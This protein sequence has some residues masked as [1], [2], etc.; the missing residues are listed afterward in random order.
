M[1]PLPKLLDLGTGGE[2]S[3]AAAILTHTHCDCSVRPKHRV[4]SEFAHFVYENDKVM[5]ENFTERFIDHRHIGFAP[6]TVSK[7][8]FH[9]RE[10]G[11]H[12]AVQSP[13]ALPPDLVA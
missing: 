8:A 9:H 11:L 12:I 4:N 5:T 7:L 10:R 13:G 3:L 6:Q 2:V 1:V